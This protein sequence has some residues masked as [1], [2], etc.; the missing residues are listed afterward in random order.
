M[1]V[2]KYNL[3]M[4]MWTYAEEYRSPSFGDF[5][6]RFTE[7]QV[8][9]PATNTPFGHTG[10]MKF[11]TLQIIRRMGFKD[12]AITGQRRTHLPNVLNGIFRESFRHSDS[13]LGLSANSRL[14]AW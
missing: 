7:T 5:M 14:M 1:Y 4:N 13:G 3:C 8:R 10:Y 2:A 6:F 12:I 11:L 9:E